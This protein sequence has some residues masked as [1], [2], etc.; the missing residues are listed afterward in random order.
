[1]KIWQ[2][3]HLFI[4]TSHTD[5]R[6]DGRTDGQKY[7]TYKQLFFILNTGSLRNMCPSL[8]GELK[9]NSKREIKLLELHRY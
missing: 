2:T 9:K 6:A 7:F 1:M 8:G 4:T 3:F 5:R